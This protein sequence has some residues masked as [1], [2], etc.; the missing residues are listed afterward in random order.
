[1]DPL[2][3]LE[4][5]G[6]VGLQTAAVPLLAPGERWQLTV[7]LR[8]PRGSANPYGFDY[9]AWLLER[10]IRATGNVRVRSGNHLL[11]QGVHAPS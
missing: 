4:R 7:R 5:D 1:M 11:T 6:D 8:R 9:E 2:L 10:D 3:T